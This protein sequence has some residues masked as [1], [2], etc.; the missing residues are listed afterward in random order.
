MSPRRFQGLLRAGG[1][2]GAP[3]CV[4]LGSVLV[5]TP[6]SGVQPGER[7]RQRPERG[8]D[9]IGLKSTTAQTRRRSDLLPPRACF[10]YQ[11]AH[12]GSEPSVACLSAS[13]QSSPRA[14]QS[15][16]AL[17]A[18]VNLPSPVNPLTAYPLRSQ[19]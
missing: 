16:E 17:L 9:K 1:S 18:A 8:R 19:P 13:G 4:T 14:A 3:K 10:G 15:C 7:S 6:G 12:L 11:V 2:Q 5:Q